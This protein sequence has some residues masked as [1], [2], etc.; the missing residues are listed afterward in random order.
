M[1][2]LQNQLNILS[3]LTTYPDIKNM[4]TFKGHGTTITTTDEQLI[5]NAENTL[6]EKLYNSTQLVIPYSKIVKT[7]TKKGGIFT[8][9]RIHVVFTDNNNVETKI[10]LYFVPIFQK[11]AFDEL[12]KMFT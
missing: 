6:T 7:F 1:L 2:S 9:H 10:I 12:S 5:I 3:E 11:Q 8:T 4:T